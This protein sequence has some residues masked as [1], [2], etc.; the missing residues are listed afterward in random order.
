MINIIFSLHSFLNVLKN[1]CVQ[2]I[3]RMNHDCKTRMR[4]WRRNSVVN[5]MSMR[6][7]VTENIHTHT[8]TIMYQIIEINEIKYYMNKSHRPLRKHDEK[9]VLVLMVIKEQIK[10]V[11]SLQHLCHV[12]VINNL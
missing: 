10:C 2:I 9:D 6:K 5:A 7:F 12:C 3:C 11:K 1:I 8:R 4:Y